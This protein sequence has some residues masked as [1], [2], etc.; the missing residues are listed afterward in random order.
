MRIPLDKPEPDIKHFVEVIRGARPAKKIPFVELIIDGKV[1]KYICETG[2]GRE[3]VLPGDR[4]S[5]LQYIDTTIQAWYRL[6]YD[7]VRLTPCAGAQ[8]PFSSKYRPAQDT[9]SGGVRN[10]TEEG[11]GMIASWEDFETYPW[12][13]VDK[14][15]Y[16]MF[17]EAARMLPEGMGILVCPS[18][19]FFEIPLN[20]LLG[21]E[22]LAYL[23]YDNPELV[24][25]V[26]QRVGEI[27]YGWYEG[28]IGLDKMVGFFQGDDMGFKT[29]TMVAPEFLRQHVFPWH[30]KLAALAHRHGLIYILHACGNMEPIMEDLINDVKIDAKHS[31]E[32]EIMPVA[33]FSEKYAGRVT[34]LG[35]IDVD[36]LSR[37]SEPDLREYVSTVIDR[38]VAN[39][40]YALGS[41]NSIAN[42]V[43]L[44]SYFIMLDEGLRWGEDN[45]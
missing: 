44:D 19:G 20:H 31:F 14:L 26:F 27:L 39:G 17:E 29:A 6:G 15:D 42:Y 13:S 12:P 22:N 8:I 45:L 23:S 28:I 11:T 9:A 1:V 7:Y 4:E 5:T 34:P 43:P 10:W 35:G 2:L 41:G 24:S 16:W 32:D 36:K 21:Y 37:F 33:E 38:C 40:G 18:S 30:K 25:A 3:W